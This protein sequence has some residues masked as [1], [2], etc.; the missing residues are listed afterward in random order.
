MDRSPLPKNCYM[1]HN[2]THGGAAA[3]GA[4]CA[5]WTM[6]P[7]W[8]SE[9][10]SRPA[11]GAHPASCAPPAPVRAV[12]LNAIDL[13]WDTVVRFSGCGLPEAFYAD[14]AR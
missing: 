1:L 10:G 4:K 13:A 6:L 7:A 8:G 12:E 5:G 3:A 11:S 2:L 9:L 14:F